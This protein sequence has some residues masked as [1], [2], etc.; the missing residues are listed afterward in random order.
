VATFPFSEPVK[1]EMEFF[2]L[3]KR[4]LDRAKTTGKNKTISASDLLAEK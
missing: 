2:A 3:A 1:N 4:A